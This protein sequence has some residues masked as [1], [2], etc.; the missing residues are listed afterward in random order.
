MGVVQELDNAVRNI[1]ET[2]SNVGVLNNTI[3]IFSTDNGGA[4]N[5]FENNMG[6]NF[7]LRSGKGYYFEGG[8]RGSAFVFGP[9]FKNR[10]GNVSTD[11]MHVTDWL[12]TLYEAAGGSVSDL[13]DVDGHSMWSVLTGVNKTC[14]RTEVLVNINPINNSKAIRVGKYKYLLNPYDVMDAE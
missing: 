9:M 1:T 5:G 13:G 8:I 3:I 12:P 7:P 10:A 2:L 11:L 4:P 14:P 6:S